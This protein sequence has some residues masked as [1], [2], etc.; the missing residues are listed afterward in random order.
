MTPADTMIGPAASRAQ[1]S[2]SQELLCAL[3]R[4]DTAGPLSQWYTITYGLRLT[5][6]VDTAAL[7]GALNDVVARHEILRTQLVRDISGWHQRIHH[8]EPVQLELCDRLAGSAGARDES[9]QHL[10]NEVEARPFNVRDV[11]LLRAVLARLADCD[12]VLALRTHH[13]AADAW[14]MQVIIRDLA[15]LYAARGGHGDHDLRPAFQYRQFAGWQRRNSD[16]ARI[17]RRYWRGRLSGGQ[18][19]TLPTDRVLPPGAAD[20]YSVER[21]VVDA[22]LGRAANRLATSNRS[23][24]FVVLLAAFNVLAFRLTGVTDLVVP[25]F[26]SGRHYPGCQDAVGP[27]YN[28]LPVRTDISDCGSFLDV[29]SRTRAS[30]LGT[31]EKDIPFRCIATEAVDLM[32]PCADENRAVAAFEMIPPGIQRGQAGNIGY[33][34]IRRRVLSQR[35][36][37]ST[38]KGMLWAMDRLPSGEIVAMVRFSRGRFEALTI[39]ALTAQYRQVL[40]AC[41]ASPAAQSVRA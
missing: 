28:L 25:T 7:Q 29:V 5:G 39:A 16:A 3:D 38:P 21:F 40:R 8:P 32:R 27:Y 41:V 30:C 9:A 17:A 6:P 36:G 19:L 23:S 34:E 14:S 11:P 12:F 15:A 18:V 4:G 37:A 33:C 10:L 24:L 22:E 35:S 20:P 31:Y 26:T 13:V 2:W 1:L